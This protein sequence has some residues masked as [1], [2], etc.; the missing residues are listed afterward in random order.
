MAPSPRLSIL[1]LLAAAAALVMLAKPASA[2]VHTVPE[3]HIGVYQQWG[4]ILNQTSEAGLHFHNPFTTTP[5]YVQFTLQTDRVRN[6][7][8]GTKEGITIMFDTIEVDNQ[9]DKEHALQTVKKFGV[10][11]DQ[12]W[13]FAKIHHE[14][15]QFCSA[16]TLQ[17]VYID[18]FS[19]IDE[20]LALALQDNCDR[21]ETG[22]T[23]I[24][25]RVTKPHIP[26]EIGRN[27]EQLSRQ[28]TEMEIQNREFEL[29]KKRSERLRMEDE[30][31]A[32]REANVD[33]INAE[34]LA[35]VSM[36]NE[37]K[38]TAEQEEEGRRRLLVSTLEQ[39]K[40]TAEKRAESERAQMELEM[41]RNRKDTELEVHRNL[42][43][44]DTDNALRVK[45][46]EM[47]IENRRLTDN[48]VRLKQTESIASAI[49][50]NTKIY[51]GDKLPDFSNMFGLDMVR[52]LFG[53]SQETTLP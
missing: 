16:H 38:L 45:R 41:Y 25:I 22:L 9:L 4:A 26:Q 43:E 40:L 8:C 19:Q 36:I 28:K 32:L 33:R 49:A 10:D 48:Y 44:T 53:K 1:F 21:Y 11:Y 14:I 42:I 51:F 46:E 29:S 18:Q 35:N 39:E 12:K 2:F 24:S 20:S 3:G 52:S 23:I 30:M 15:N 5:H 13:I 34:R 50:S 47:E 27:Y 37:K 7:P 31:R 17:E 6:I